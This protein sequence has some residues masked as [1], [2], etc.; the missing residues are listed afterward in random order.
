[1]CRGLADAL[2]RLGR[3]VVSGRKTG[4]FLNSA[5]LHVPLTAARL[6]VGPASVVSQA[7]PRVPSPVTPPLLRGADAA[8]GEGRCEAGPPPPVSLPV[9]SVLSSET[10]LQEPRADRPP[11]FPHIRVR[12]S[13]VLG[14]LL[15]ATSGRADSSSQTCPRYSPQRGF[16]VS[17]SFL[18][19]RLLS[20]RVSAVRVRRGFFVLTVGG[21]WSLIACARQSVG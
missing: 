8:K 19:L 9:P 6:T 21:C 10:R 20:G 7:L 2:P 18:T 17:V 11:R 5:F 13:P 14:E 4:P 1:M 3:G 15:G 16:R 12:F